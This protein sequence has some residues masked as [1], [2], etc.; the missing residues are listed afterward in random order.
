MRLVLLALSDYDG[1]IQR[2][3]S[4]GMTCACSHT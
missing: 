4:N 3:G 1:L 2:T